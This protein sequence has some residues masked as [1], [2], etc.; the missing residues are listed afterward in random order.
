MNNLMVPTIIVHVGIFKPTSHKQFVKLAMEHA[1]ISRL[2]L[3]ENHKPLFLFSTNCWK[4]NNKGKSDGK[5]ND[6]TKR[7][8]NKQT[9]WKTGHHKPKSSKVYPTCTVFVWFHITFA[10]FSTSSLALAV[11]LGRKI[12]SGVIFCLDYK[13]LNA[14]IPPYL[15][16]RLPG[17]I[18]QAGLLQ[19][20]D[21]GKKPMACLNGICGSEEV[22]IRLLKESVW[23]VSDAS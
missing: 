12:D 4:S 10:A 16:Q 1:R 19:N 13:K 20:A 8:T 11:V 6:Q 15:C 7:I 3:V 21:Y 9:H 14:F 23:T 2:S 18:E 5:R 17:H 22:G